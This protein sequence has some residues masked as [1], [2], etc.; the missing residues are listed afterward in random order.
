MAE[1]HILNSETIDKIA[2]GEVVERP[3]SVVKELVENAIDAGATAITV[4]AKD[5]GIEF[6]R[7][8]DTGCGM[9]KEQ[10]RKAFLRHATSKIE[11]AEDLMRISSLG[12]RGEA[13][14]SIAAV[15]KV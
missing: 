10:L 1:I 4:E 11:S 12:F 7:V 3:S 5:G 9:E 14:S 8:T 2:A 13:L 6:I 15:S